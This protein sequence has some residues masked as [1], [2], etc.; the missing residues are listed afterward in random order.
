MYLRFQRLP[1]SEK[2][3]DTWLAEGPY[4]PPPSSGTEKDALVDRAA[5]HHTAFQQG[6]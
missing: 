4:S 1:S 5:S 2:E 3:K 6:G